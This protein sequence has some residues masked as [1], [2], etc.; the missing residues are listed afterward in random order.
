ANFTR[1]MMSRMNANDYMGVLP[2]SNTTLY[3]LYRVGGGDMSNIAA[4][5]L[6]TIISSNLTIEGCVDDMNDSQKIRDVRTS[7]SV[8]NTTPSYGGKDEPTADELRYMIKY[9]TGAQNRGVTVKDYYAILQQMPAKYGMP[10]RYCVSEENNKIVFYTLGLD[11]NGYLTEYLAETVADNMKKWLSG[12]KCVN[13]FIEFRSG[14]IINLS[15]VV[16]LYVDT[17][18]EKG[19]VVKRVIDTIDDYMDIR[20]HQMGEDI[21]LGDLQ[22]EI[23][24]LDGVENYTS[25]RVFNLTGEDYSSSESTMP[26][27]STSDCCYSDALEG[28]YDGNGTELDLRYTD[29]VLVA[30][31]NSMFEIKYKNKDIRIIAKTR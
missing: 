28:I 5:T 24:K 8:T 1:Y 23:S 12:Y 27:V 2:E 14:K 26:L 10:F 17:A 15:F 16:T 9:A 22:K 29:N 13:D 21:Y 31:N 3:V 11:Y 18:Y 6:N 30:D 4:G 20:R 25:M 19:E 7:L